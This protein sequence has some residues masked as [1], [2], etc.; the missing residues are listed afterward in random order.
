VIQPTAAFPLFRAILRPTP[1][2]NAIRYAE[3]WQ[4]QYTDEVRKAVRSILANDRGH[5]QRVRARLPRRREGREDAG[6]QDAIGINEHLS[7]IAEA[8]LG[9]AAI[10][11]QPGHQFR[12]GHLKRPDNDL[13]AQSWPRGRVRPHRNKFEVRRLWNLGVI[14]VV[15]KAGEH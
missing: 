13:A 9:D 12:L 2:A 15:M 8:I 5:G 7:E 1:T 10:Y 6:N 11:E 14:Y 4:W 3:L